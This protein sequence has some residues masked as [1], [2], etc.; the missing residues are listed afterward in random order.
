MIVFSTSDNFHCYLLTRLD[1]HKID[2][3]N[4]KLLELRSRCGNE[5]NKL[6]D[7]GGEDDANESD[8]TAV[9]EQTLNND[10]ETN[11]RGKEF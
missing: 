3:N 2:K 10:D 7:A 6:Q 8:I 9:T 4:Q 1:L 11:L 5:Q